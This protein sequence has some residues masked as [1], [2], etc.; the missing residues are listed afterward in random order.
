MHKHK[1]KVNTLVAGTLD[2][3]WGEYLG[4]A[5]Y[6]AL[7]G[8]VTTFAVI[9]GA[10]GAQLSL[11]FVIILGLANLFADGFSM[12]VGNFLGARSQQQFSEDQR[13][14][15]TEAVIR[16]PDETAKTLSVLYQRKGFIS[17]LLDEIVAQLA[18]NS[19]ATVNELMIEQELQPPRLKPISSALVTFFSFVLVGFI[20]IIPLLIIPEINFWVLLIL[21]AG[22]LFAVGS[23][24]SRVTAV[25]WWRGGLE[26]MAAGLLASL[27]AYGVG[28]VL[29]AWVVIGVPPLPS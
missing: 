17:P 22:V 20:P 16:H 28:E 24:R 18:K 8:T 11:P 19:G 27:I 12:A 4:D 26:I 2:G 23:L 9:A 10:V 29:S 6:G 3:K 21:V 14:K 13:R 15:L 5:I 7:D 25:T 1:R